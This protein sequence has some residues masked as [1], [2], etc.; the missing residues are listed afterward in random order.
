KQSDK[1]LVVL[2]KCEFL[3]CRFAK[4]RDERLPRDQQKFQQAVPLDERRDGGTVL[5]YVHLLQSLQRRAPTGSLIRM[6]P[7]GCG[8]THQHV[9]TALGPRRPGPAHR[10]KCHGAVIMEK[11]WLFKSAKRR[12]DKCL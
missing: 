2:Y 6:P 1:S 3:Q 9:L 4:S 10:K 7:T 11:V 8:A 12:A 5:E